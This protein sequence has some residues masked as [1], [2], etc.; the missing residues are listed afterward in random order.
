MLNIKTA[1]LKFGGEALGTPQGPFLTL[2]VEHKISILPWQERGLQ[3]T[4]SGYGFQL[5]S[6]YMVKHNGKWRRV[7]ICQFSN[8]GTAYIGKPGAWEAIVDFDYK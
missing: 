1:Y 8:T 5:T 7:Y 4:A 3:E 2:E 6:R